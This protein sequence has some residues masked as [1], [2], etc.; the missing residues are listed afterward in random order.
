MLK[1]GYILYLKDVTFLNTYKGAYK[2]N[3]PTSS[4]CVVTRPVKSRERGDIIAKNI[5]EQHAKRKAAFHRT[6]SQDAWAMEYSD[7]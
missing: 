3:I 6:A 5:T 7:Y 1:Q 4:W 2:M